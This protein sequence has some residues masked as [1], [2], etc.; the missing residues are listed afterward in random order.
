MLGVLLEIFGKNRLSLYSLCSSLSALVIN[1]DYTQLEQ[2]AQA[3][4]TSFQLPENHAPFR[5]QTKHDR[6]ENE[7]VSGVHHSVVETAAVYWEPVIK[8]YGSSI[9]K[10]L[11]ITTA[12]VPE[13]RLSQLG[14][15]CR[16]L[17]RQGCIRDGA[18]AAHR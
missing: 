8:I 14:N 16:P 9:K 2:A 17:G 12:H 5:Q 6:I 13:S 7:T 15:S 11:L 4:Q 10:D 1:T 3:L 18:H